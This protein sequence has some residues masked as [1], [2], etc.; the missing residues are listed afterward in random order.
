MEKSLK[1]WLPK[2]DIV[3]VKLMYPFGV[4]KKKS[5]NANVNYILV[6]YQNQTPQDRN[7]RTSEEKEQIQEAAHI[8]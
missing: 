7:S 6:G 3:T 1:N 2:G 4:K 8:G 5:F